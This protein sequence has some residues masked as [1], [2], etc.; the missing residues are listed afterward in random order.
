V[1]LCAAFDI[2]PVATILHAAPLFKLA[3]NQRLAFAASFAAVMLAAAGLDHL[4]RRPSESA[5][6]GALLIAY[7]VISAGAIWALNA[8][9]TAAARGDW[10]MIA[11]VVPLAVSAIVVLCRWERAAAALLLLMIV[12]RSALLVP[13]YPALPKQIA[14]PELP[15]LKKIRPTGS[16]PFRV[17]GGHLALVP[18][19]SAL[20][21]LE[22]VRGY[23]AMTLKRFVETY[24]LWCE[25][26]HM[27]FNRVGDLERPFLSMMNVRFAI[28]P[29]WMGIPD[30]WKEIDT[31]HHARL[32]EN[33]R[34]LPRAFVPLKVR[35][36]AQDVIA[37]MAGERDFAQR[38]WIEAPP[39]PAER[40]NGPGT[41]STLHADLGYELQVDMERDGWVV[42]SQGAWKGWRAYLDGR[43]V[44]F[45]RANHAFISVFVPAGRHHVRLKYF[46]HTFV[47][48]RAITFM[49]LLVLAGLAGAHALKWRTPPATV[50][51]SR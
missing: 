24:P 16:E 38:A 23:Q 31:D 48:G 10:R 21:G 11:E 26:L 33:T 51:R 36:G 12:Q 28:A 50:R 44:A 25:P 17:V 41:V 20:Y 34:S 7:A 30:G 43:R 14:Y 35:L 8:R 4:Q 46:P 40:T 39:E 5:S 15:L 27:W 22:D 47:V 3:L 42:V 1:A 9:A 49:T 6:R 19:S 45:Q 2:P 13:L 32:L 37:E 29:L 18:N